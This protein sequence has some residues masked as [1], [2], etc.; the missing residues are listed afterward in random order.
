DAVTTVTRSRPV[1]I[2]RVA[3]VLRL[4]SLR[5]ARFWGSERARVT[6]VLNGRTLRLTLKHR[7]SFA[8]WHRGTVRMLRAYAVDAAGNRSRLLKARR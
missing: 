4:L 5:S 6:L 3:P 2:D 1:R 8:V 7:G